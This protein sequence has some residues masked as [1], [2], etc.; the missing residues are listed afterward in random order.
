[1]KRNTDLKEQAAFEQAKFSASDEKLYALL[2]DELGNDDDIIIKP[3]FAPNIV[4]KLEKK[5]R[6]ENRKENLLF[7]SAIL[8]V[9]L[10]TVAGFQ[11]T[12]SL[13]QTNEQLID[14]NFVIPIIVLVGLITIFQVIDKMYIRNKRFKRLHL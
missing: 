8:G 10:V 5:R 14:S 11:F 4:V 1:M 7:I 3:D 2:F 12:K 6:K 13:L 9:I